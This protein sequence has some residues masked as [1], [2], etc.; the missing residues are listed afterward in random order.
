MNFFSSFS[1]SARI[2]MALGAALIAI[3]ALIVILTPMFALRESNSGK[4]ATEVDYGAAITSPRNE[5]GPRFTVNVVL[6]KNAIEA[7]NATNPEE[8]I[9]FWYITTNIAG[10]KYWP[11]TYLTSDSGPPWTIELKWDLKGHAQDR[12]TVILF[13]V[14]KRA[15]L[16]LDLRAKADIKYLSRDEVYVM[17]GMRELG[18]V[19]I[20][21]K[22]DL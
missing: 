9:E 15:K 22:E 13:A 6:G 19:S 16:A 5:Q 4:G 18:R 10:D 8:R 17:A 21:I 14:D 1:Q 3:G 20:M 11:Q 2:L 7:M 12:A